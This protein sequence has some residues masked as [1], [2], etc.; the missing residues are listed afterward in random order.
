MRHLASAKLEQQAARVEALQS[1]WPRKPNGGKG[2]VQVGPIIRRELQ[3]LSSCTSLVEL[4][5]SEAVAGRWYWQTLASLPVDFAAT[6][7]TSVPD[8]WHTAGARTSPPS[9]SRAHARPP[10]LLM[11]SS[12]TRT[13]F[14]RRKRR[15][16]C[17]RTASTQASG[18]SIRTSGIAGHSR[19]TSWSLSGPSWTG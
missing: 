9:A 17:K 12:T 14:W 18:F 5:A 2:Q 7:R 11:R 8:H 19:T 3:K 16:R 4:R 13:R 1:L 10:L 6:W 15:S